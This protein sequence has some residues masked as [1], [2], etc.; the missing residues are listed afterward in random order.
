M[1]QKINKIKM[2]HFYEV[3]HFGKSLAAVSSGGEGGI[4]THVPRLR[5]NPISS[6]ARYGRFATSPLCSALEW[7]CRIP[8]YGDMRGKVCLGNFSPAGKS[9]GVETARHRVVPLPY[10]LPLGR[11]RNARP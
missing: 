5:D 9:I 7:A 8:S 3:L 1:E 2:E 4:R 11:V 10:P 6:R